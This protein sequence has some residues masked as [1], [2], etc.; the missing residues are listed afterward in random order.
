MAYYR[1]ACSFFAGF[2]QH[3]IDELADIEPIQ[4]AAYVETLQASAA[5]P[6]VK[7]GFRWSKRNHRTPCSSASTGIVQPHLRDRGSDPGEV[8]LTMNSRIVFA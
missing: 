6:T 7:Q 3:G 2:E 8:D 1:A 4:V 5:K